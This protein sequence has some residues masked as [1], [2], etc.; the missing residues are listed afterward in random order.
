MSPLRS[1]PALAFA[2]VLI[3][4]AYAQSGPPTDTRVMV[5]AVSHDAKIIGSNV[6]GAR[7]LIQDAETG[8]VLA[9]GVQEGS[10]GSTE[11]IVRDPIARGDTV[12]NTEGAAGYTATL[13]LDAPTWVD[14]T[15]LG[16]LDDPEARARTTKRMLLLPGHDVLGEG[17]V[18]VLNGFTVALEAPAQAGRALDVTAEV[19]MLCGC[20][21]EP[22]GLWDADAIEVVAR[23]VREGEVVAEAP[24]R[25]TGEQSTFGGPLTAPGPGAYT[26]QV[27]A[28][29]PERANFGLAARAVS[30]P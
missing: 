30:I 15:A 13:A 1:L 8:R 10:T 24:L 21:T 19:T 14:I 2:L 16:P 17:V 5:R 18:L 3:P 29:H 12:F 23:L 22:G 28:S 11:R 9:E 27:L 4:V 25:Y 20:P 6:G 26:L 7:I